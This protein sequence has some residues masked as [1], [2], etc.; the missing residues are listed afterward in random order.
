MIMHKAESISTLT[1]F[2]INQY[3]FKNILEKIQQLRDQNEREFQIK[4]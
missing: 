3:L 2:N 1:A 4:R